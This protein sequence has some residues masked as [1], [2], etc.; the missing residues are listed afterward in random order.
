LEFAVE[1]YQEVTIANSTYYKML[2]LAYYFE[3]E[4][5]CDKA[6]PIFREVL[7]SIP[8]DE[9]AIEGL[10]LCRAATLELGS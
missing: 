7:E 9:D 6:V 4:E 5:N 8:G 10:E 3:G 2:G 1:N